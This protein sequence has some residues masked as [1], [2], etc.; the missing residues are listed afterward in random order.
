MASSECKLCSPFKKPLG[1]NSGGSMLLDDRKPAA[2]MWV[3]AE[4]SLSLQKSLLRKQGREV[5]LELSWAGPG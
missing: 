2:G 5:A 4:G 3:K 1:L